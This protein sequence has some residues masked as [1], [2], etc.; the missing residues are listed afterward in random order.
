MAQIEQEGDYEELFDNSL[1]PFQTYEE[2]LDS[3]ITDEDRYY[4]QDI[5]LAR[6]L[7]EQG[8]QINLGYHS[9]TEILSK[10]AFYLK[11]Q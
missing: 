8:T 11:K 5:E 6:Q 2:Y 1:D 4:L 10:E 3:H 7:K 9:K